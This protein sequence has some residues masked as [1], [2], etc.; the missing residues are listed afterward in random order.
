MR[1]GTVKE[2]TSIGG[3]DHVVLIVVI[4]GHALINIF[5]TYDLIDHDRDFSYVRT[6]VIKL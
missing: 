2:W 3:Q 6:N 5:N 1:K 4:L